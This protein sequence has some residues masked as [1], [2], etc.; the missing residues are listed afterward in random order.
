MDMTDRPTPDETDRPADPAS[1]ESPDVAAE[2]RAAG[3]DCLRCGSRIQDLGVFELRTGGSTG[4]A[5][6]LFGNWAELGEDKIAVEVLT[7]PVCRHLEF[8]APR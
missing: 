2:V 8:R 4:A 5:H 1:G 6:L 3:L 7:C